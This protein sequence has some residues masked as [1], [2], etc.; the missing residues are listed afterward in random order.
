MSVFVFGRKFLKWRNYSPVLILPI[1]TS[2]SYR[3]SWRLA[4]AETVVGK[5]QRRDVATIVVG[6]T[7][8]RWRCSLLKHRAATWLW[9]VPEPPPPL[10]MSSFILLPIIALSEALL[11]IVGD[12]HDGGKPGKQKT[13]A[14]KETKF[15]ISY[16]KNKKS[17]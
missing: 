11:Y 9:G 5:R 15:N 17:I 3:Y 8:Q 16:M 4:A 13:L 6:N 14:K 10:S 7:L 2:P 12:N 1:L